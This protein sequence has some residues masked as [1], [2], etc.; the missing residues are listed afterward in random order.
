[1]P[2]IQIENNIAAAGVVANLFA[3]SAYEF[4]RGRTLVS[5]GVVA[6]ATGTFVTIQSGSDVLLEESPPFVLAG[7]PL[8]PDHMY[9]NDVMENGDRL[10][11]SAR[12]PSG[13]AVIHRALALMSAVG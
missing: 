5:L 11:V 13:G 2:A 8:V 3:G 10:R 4:S 6:A 12:N 7:F 9:Y 1:M